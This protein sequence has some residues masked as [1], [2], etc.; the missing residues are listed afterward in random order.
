MKL[1]VVM[2]HY[3]F[4]PLGGGEIVA[5]NSMKHLSKRHSIDLICFQPRDS[6][7]QPDS[8]ISK[9]ILVPQAKVSKVA[10]WLR[11][12]PYLLADV[13]VSVTT[14]TFIAM[15]RKVKEA[16]G[17]SD[18]DV[19]LLFDMSAIRYCPAF[20]YSKLIVNIENPHA[21]QL[22]R[23]RMLDG[24]I[25]SF[26]QRAK[27]MILTMLAARYEKKIFPKM[28]KILMLS[29]ADLQ[30]MSNQYGYDN[31]AQVPYGVEQIDSSGIP[32]Y[33]QRERTIIYSGNMFHP[34]NV[35]GALFLLRDVFPLILQ[36]YP[37]AILWIV[38]ANPDPRIYDA[39]AKFGAQVLIMGKV[40][41]IADYIKRATVSICPIRLK[42]GVQTKILEALSWGTPVVTT[43]AGNS[44]VSGVSG[45][46]LWVEDEPHL[47]ANRVVALLQGHDWTRLSADGRRFVTEHFSWEGSAAQLEKHLESFVASH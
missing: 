19:V 10:K 30:D 44:G 11:H 22:R 23:N 35:D 39:A 14:S 46:H 26:W 16:L 34:P 2:T 20:C 1:L 31:L 18:Y 9:T 8:F 33:E 40:P 43:S 5:Y 41:D 13:P 29:K 7:V 47:F 17:R 28:G 3:P 37:A 12:L 32:C 24:P 4:P 27:L 45:T 25:W 42:I 15:K 21:I 38:G 36:Q 6:F